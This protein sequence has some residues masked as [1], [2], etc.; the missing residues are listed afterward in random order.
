MLSALVTAALVCIMLLLVARLVFKALREHRRMRTQ[1]TRT[2]LP[3][4]PLDQHVTVVLYMQDGIVVDIEKPV[5]PPVLT[6]PSS[7]YSRHRTLVSLGLILMLLLAFLIQG[8]F[9][10]EALLNL[11]KS[12]DLLGF[13]QGTRVQT[14]A[15]LGP[16]TASQRLIRLDSG[17][18]DQYLTV[19]QWRVWAYSS[20]SGFAM[21]EVMNAYG[22]H[23]IASD[24]L[25]VELN[26]GVWSVPSGLLRDEGI[27]MTANY[28]GFNASLS[29]SRTLQNLI[30]TGN[31]GTPVI[32]SVRDNHY[33]P[34]G[35]IFVVRGGDGQYV[36]IADSSPAN[37]TRMTYAM[38]LGMWQA[39]SFSAV[40]TPR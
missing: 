20:C 27:S 14:A 39:R 13:S 25:Q 7:W 33:F 24:V 28:F 29:Y 4:H 38:F 36:Y 17:A 15:Q 5:P 30:T 40:L 31:K 6:L 9:A 2:H 34:G 26:L 19:N 37:F 23:L 32:V 8:G 22:R 21:A 1:I 18:R 35:H 12:L 11:T 3:A 16:L 10:G